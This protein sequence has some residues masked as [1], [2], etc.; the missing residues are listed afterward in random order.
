MLLILGLVKK[1]LIADSLASLSAVAFRAAAA[2]AQAGLFPSPLYIQ[3]FYLYAFQIYADFSGYTDLARASAAFLGFNLPENFQQPYLSATVTTFW[4]R[5]HMTLT[6][7]FREYL[8]FPL[9][10]KLLLKYSKKHAVA[11]QTFAN[12]VTMILIGFWHGAA[13]IFVAWGIW[14]GL[15]LV[16]EN[17]LRLKPKLKTATI[18]RGVLTFHLVGIGWVLFGSLSFEAAWR[19]LIGLF[20]FTQMSWLPH[21]L[22]S[23][24]LTAGLVFGIDLLSRG[25]IPGQERFR[26]VWQP[27]ADYC[28]F[29]RLEQFVTFEYS[30][31]Q[32]CFT[33]YLRQILK[34]AG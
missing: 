4:N 5:W 14:H 6:Q 20:S 23:I 22:P 17:I 21:Y 19:F 32:H 30:T 25:S 33:I 29:N 31:R 13:W 10:R 9:S 34:V 18:I 11:I 7:W 16:I 2:P 26:S 15:L 1:I 8:F 3:G 12:L 28:W 27:V 24:L